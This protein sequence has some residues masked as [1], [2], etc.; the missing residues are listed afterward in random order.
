MKKSSNA[1]FLFFFEGFIIL[2]SNNKIGKEENLKKL[3]I[4]LFIFIMLCGFGYRENLVIVKEK[5]KLFSYSLPY[6]NHDDV[7]ISANYTTKSS[8]SEIVHDEPIVNDLIEEKEEVLVEV[9]KEEKKTVQEETN[10]ESVKEI[11]TTTAAKKE[12]EIEYTKKSG[13]YAPN[14]TYLGK[15][16][17]KVI[18]VS[19]YQKNIDWDTFY[20]SGEYYGVI[21]RLGFYTT[22]DKSFERNLRELKRLNI[23]YGIYLFSYAT[24]IIGARAEAEFTNKMIDKYDIKPILG[25]Y[26]DL[27]SWKSNNLS[28]DSITKNGY[29]YIAK[30]Y[31][32]SVKT[33]VNNNYKVGIYSGR[34]YAMNRLGNIAK[35]Y[36]LWVAEYN[37]TCKYDS[38][39]IM[40]QYT[41]KGSVPGI[42]GYVDISYL[43]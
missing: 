6:I 17:V 5:N 2:L 42:N 23:P 13:Y 9:P 29:N 15:K 19:Y 16:N 14:G 43:F 12:D 26:Y 10:V 36:V 11:E 40:W 27:E 21:L 25:I 7:I 3:I 34:W 41:S 39:Y 30:A 37:K 28:T 24:S 38:N 32:E 22:F 35:S 8:S 1:T 20:N 33:H 31:V 18:D 4:F